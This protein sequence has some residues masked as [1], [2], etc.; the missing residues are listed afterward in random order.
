[1]F[2]FLS[3]NAQF[4][5]VLEISP[6]FLRSMNRTGVLLDVDCT[7]KDYGSPTVPPAVQK[8]IGELRE[9]GLRPCLLS[10]GKSRRIGPLANILG[11]P[12]VA[13]AFKPLP[14]GCRAALRLLDLPA[15]RTAI[16]GDHV[17]ADILAGNLAKLLTILV[18]PTTDVEPI[19]TRVK[20]PFER[21]VL[22]RI[23]QPSAARSERPS[24]RKL[25]LHQPE[26]SPS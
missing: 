1:M 22:R 18:R 2:S 23:G 24:N 10:N 13:K 16:I 8:W 3:P 26:I 19:W 25:N 15:S 21:F 7:L 14:F 9:S 12:F 4:D 5:N 11:I 17:F 6:E 20:R